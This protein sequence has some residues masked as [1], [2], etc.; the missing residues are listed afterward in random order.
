MIGHIAPEAA[1]GG[2]IGLV[3]EGDEIVIDVDARRLD[4]EVPADVLEQRRG[5][6]SPPPPRYASGVLAKYAALVS[7]ASE[8]AVTTG[9][10]MHAALDGATGVVPGT[11]FADTVI[12]GG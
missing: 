10:R 1:L 7:S 3:E 2:P 4:L 9:R 11:A 8:G 12:S 6:W 5:H